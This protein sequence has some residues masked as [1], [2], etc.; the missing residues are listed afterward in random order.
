MKSKKQTGDLYKKVLGYNKL[1][2]S[3]SFCFSSSTA[4]EGVTT[5]LANL[6][7][8]IKNQGTERSVIVIDA[9]LDSSDQNEIFGLPVNSFGLKD[10]LDNRVDIQSALFPV[11]PGISVMGSGSP[12]EYRHGGIE[13]DQFLKVV[14]SCK[15]FADYVLIDCP[16]I[17]SSSDAFSVAPAADI[18]FLIVQAVKVRRQVA[19][20]GISALQ[21]SECELGGIIM[22][23]VQQVI[24]SWV[25]KYI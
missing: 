19:E 12:K 15:Q 17:L 1:S 3:N 22:N 14:N 18:T 4:G 7:N 20:R 21:N 25:Y 9:N 16:P 13:P 10:V 5:I 8:Y 6:V 2:Q 23:R 11:A 24:P